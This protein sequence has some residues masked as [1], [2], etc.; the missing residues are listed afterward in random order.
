MVPIVK[1]CRKVGFVNQVLLTC[2]VELFL[3]NF[4]IKRILP[5]L[6]L[7]FWNEEEATSNHSTLPVRV[8]YNVT[9]QEELH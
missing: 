8:S 6:P 4:V 3:L 5:K 7:T 2:L 1:L 9:T